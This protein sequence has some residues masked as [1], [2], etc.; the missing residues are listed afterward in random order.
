MRHEIFAV[1]DTRTREGR[2]GI[3][4]INP[5]QWSGWIFNGD[6]TAT[7][8]AGATLWGLAELVTGEGKNWTKIEGY[9]G[10]PKRMPIGQTV[11]YS[12][13]T[14][15][16]PTKILIVEGTTHVHKINDIK[17]QIKRAIQ[18]LNP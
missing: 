1:I 8:E 4:Y 12:M 15:I 3:L 13:L 11:N 5:N 7:A 18:V 16:I 14:L 17:S 10:E 9:T 6:G 2:T